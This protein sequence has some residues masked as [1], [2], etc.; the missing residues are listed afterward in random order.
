MFRIIRKIFGT[1]ILIAGIS[2]IGFFGYIDHKIENMQSKTL[3]AQSQVNE[4]SSSLRPLVKR[5]AKSAQEKIDTAN[6]EILNISERANRILILG[7]I[8]T[9]SGIIV[10]IFPRKK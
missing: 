9:I 1:L 10:I 2:L 4:K 8:L 6:K 3:E 7:I 5:G